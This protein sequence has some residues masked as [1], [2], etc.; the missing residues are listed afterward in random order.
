MVTNLET[1]KKYVGKK[2]YHSQRSEAVEGKKR[3]RRYQVESNWKSYITSCKPLKE[4][5]KELGMDSFHFEIIL[6]CATKAWHTYSEV[7]L[8]HKLDVLT[9]TLEDGS[10]AFY[11]NNIGAIKFIPPT[12]RSY[13]QGDSH[14]TSRVDGVDISHMFSESAVA[15]RSGD[16]H[17][18]RKDPDKHPRLGVVV[19]EETRCKISKALKGKPRLDLRG[20]R[21]PNYKLARAV[22]TPLGTFERL[23]D[24]ADAHNIKYTT[25]RSRAQREHKGW[26]Y[27]TKEED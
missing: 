24:A 1:G 9:A 12:D 26:R 22:V 10:R 21:G 13:M 7:N 20:E 25:A 23:Q 6:E 27:K 5:I 8:Q 19:E 17:Y 3:R 16:N 14:W 15:K 4:D 11:N 18:L 2:Q